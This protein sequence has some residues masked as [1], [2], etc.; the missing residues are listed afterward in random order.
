MSHARHR[1][2]S[3]LKRRKLIE[4]QGGRCVYCGVLFDAVHPP[5]MDHFVPFSHSQS[6]NLKNFVASCVPCNARKNG[7]VFDSIEEVR[8]FLKVESICFSKQIEFD[9]VLSLDPLRCPPAPNR[10]CSYCSVFFF[11]K[12]L[13]QIYCSQRCSNDHSMRENQIRL[14]KVVKKCGGCGGE[15]ITSRPQTKYCSS[16]CGQKSWENMRKSK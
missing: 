15:Y 7:L 4:D 11:S 9:F 13:N 10:R 3:L 6:N 14:K 12:K 8:K 2:P 5:C 16:T 1:I